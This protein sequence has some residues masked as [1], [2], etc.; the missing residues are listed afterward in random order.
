M[1]PFRRQSTPHDMLSTAEGSLIDIAARMFAAVR[2]RERYKWQVSDTWLAQGM[3]DELVRIQSS[4][5][6]ELTGI[7]RH[8]LLRSLTLI[9]LCHA[10]ILSSS[11]FM[12]SGHVQP[13]QT[14][15]QTSMHSVSPVFAIGAR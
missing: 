11:S 14:L 7:F 1:S 10:S 8:Q 12:M 4:Y 15:H 5:V 9:L 3:E 2:Y 6:A 13:R